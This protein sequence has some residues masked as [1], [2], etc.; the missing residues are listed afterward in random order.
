MRKR[1]AAPSDPIQVRRFDF[2]VAQ[3]IDRFKTLIV[4]KD[5]QDI[6]L[7]AQPVR[8]GWQ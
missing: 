3:V 6:G 5:E 1:G 2:F 4:G 8:C 7:V